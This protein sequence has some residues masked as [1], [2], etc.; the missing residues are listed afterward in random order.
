[1]VSFSMKA[2]DNDKP[3]HRR[4][5]TLSLFTW[6]KTTELCENEACNRVLCKC[7]MLLCL[8]SSGR[9]CERLWVSTLHERTQWCERRP[10]L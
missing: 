4:F 10:C 2:P 5:Q 7:L 3:S 6:A 1:M 9:L 8:T